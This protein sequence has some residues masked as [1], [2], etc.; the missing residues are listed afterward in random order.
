[1]ILTETSFEFRGQKGKI[2]LDEYSLGGTCLLFLEE[3]EDQVG[4]SPI[5]ISLRI[6]GSQPTSP[7]QVY[8]KNYSEFDGVLIE[9]DRQGIIKPAN[10]R[11]WVRLSPWASAPLVTLSEEISKFL[12]PP[13]SPEE[14]S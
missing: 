1:M 4:G 12:P 8:I 10:S 14:E 11:M 5:P 13:L 7:N 2:A 6:P 9:L 3:G